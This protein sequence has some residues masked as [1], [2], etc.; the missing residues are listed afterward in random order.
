MFTKYPIHK[1]TLPNGCEVAYIDEGVGSTTLLFVHGLANYAGVWVKNIEA[2]KKHYRCIAID[3]PGN[4]YSDKGDHP[5]GINFFADTVYDFI[6]QMKLQNLVPVGHSMGGQVSLRLVIN[7][8][9]ACNKLVL[10]APA[11]FESFT[12]LE[13]TIY[14]TGIR[15]LDL[16]STEENSL[17]EVTRASF[18]H[19]PAFAENML[20]ELVDLMKQQPVN[21]YRKMV[22]SCINGMLDE[23]VFSELRNIRQ[24][25]LVMYGE[26]DALIPNKLIHPISTRTLAEKAVAE[27]PDAT[28]KMLPECGHFVQLEEAELVNEHIRQFVENDT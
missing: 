9:A 25:V 22:E 15:F 8:P 3:L 6:R 17:R 24:K 10:C 14:K 12:A 4:G 21:R 7:H 13:R 11:G 2:L 27:L 19:Y 16:F 1:V 26:R 18:Y 20:Q 28:L 5:Y 23:P